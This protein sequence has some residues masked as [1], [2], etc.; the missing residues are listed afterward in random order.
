M[1]CVHAFNNVHVVLVIRSVCTSW[2]V[3]LTSESSKLVIIQNI[4]YIPQAVALFTMPKACALHVEILEE[5]QFLIACSIV[6]VHGYACVT[7]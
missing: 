5:T 1:L 7:P 2:Y 6:I 4:C 3:S